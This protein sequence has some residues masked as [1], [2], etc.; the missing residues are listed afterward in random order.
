MDCTYFRELGSAIIDNEANEAQVKEFNDHISTCDACKT[1]F[2]TI[3]VL[4]NETESMVEN[5]PVELKTRV[6]ASIRNENK[7]PSFFS[8][9][10]FTAVAA[11][12]AIIIFAANGFMHNSPQEIT[13]QTISETPPVGSRMAPLPD[14]IAVGEATDTPENIYDRAFSYVIYIKDSTVNDVLKDLI[15]EEKD[16][17]KYYITD[18]KYDTFSSY[19]QEIIALNLSLETEGLVITK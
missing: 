14:Q 17:Y 18:M 16:G 11:A 10:R 15:F 4:K 1:W 5:V 9:F 12:V 19:S 7:K 8:R 3:K 6:M 13:P 2:E